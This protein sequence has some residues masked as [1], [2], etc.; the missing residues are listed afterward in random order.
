V[1]RPGCAKHFPKN[2][3]ILKNTAQTLLALKRVGSSQQKLMCGRGEG[4]TAGGRGGGRNEASA[5]TGSAQVLIV[6]MSPQEPRPPKIPQTS[7]KGPYWTNK[8]SQSI[9]QES[10]PVALEKRQ[11]GGRREEE[12]QHK[13][14]VQG[15]CQKKPTHKTVLAKF[16]RTP[17]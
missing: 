14:R 3:W 17:A 6:S 15:E 4:R 11:A 10:A 7:T 16:G 12:R 2:G 5:R 9:P 1:Q 13:P 8:I